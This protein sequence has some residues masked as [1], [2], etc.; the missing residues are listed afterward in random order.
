MFARG[1]LVSGGTGNDLHHAQLWVPKSENFKVHIRRLMVGT[2]GAWTAL[3]S[4]TRLNN[5]PFAGSPKDDGIDIQGDFNAQSK[6]ELRDE[7]RP[8]ALGAQLFHYQGSKEFRFDHGQFIVIPNFADTS[9]TGG[10]LM[11]RTADLTPIYVSF[12][13]EEESL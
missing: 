4:S 13:W 8:L 11:I 1:T 10:S 12:F 3:S 2:T 5:H 9:E 7:R 6:A